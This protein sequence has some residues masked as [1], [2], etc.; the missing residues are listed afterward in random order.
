MHVPKPD[1][2]RW[3]EPLSLMAVVLIKLLIYFIS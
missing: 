1:P 3:A 2:F